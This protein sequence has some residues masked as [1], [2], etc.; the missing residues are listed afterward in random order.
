[1][2][3]INTEYREEAKRKIITAALEVATS[4]GWQRV[5]LET[6]A[7]KVG[8]TKGAF[9]SYFPS[10]TVL[11]QDVVIGMIRTIRDQ[12]L[13]ELS[14]GADK[15]LEIDRVGDFLFSRIKPIFPAFVQAMASEIPREPEFRQRLS[16][17]LDENHEKIVA[18]LSRYQ[19]NGQIPEEVNLSSAVL[20]IY[21]MSI[22]LGMMTH[23]LGKD[24]AVI[25]QV[26]TDTVRKILSLPA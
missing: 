19:E 9:Y 2:P 5:T 3:R 10:S 24:S 17:L 13:D 22:G 6:I 21:G 16:G 1:M 25:K 14:E 15:E 20:S 26:W 18:V 8:V 4:D 12:L 23:V 11:M 7:R